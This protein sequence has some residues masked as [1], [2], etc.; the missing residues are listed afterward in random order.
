MV[1]TGR[2]DEPCANIMLEVEDTIP[3]MHDHYFINA[4]RMSV[5]GFEKRNSIEMPK[6]QRFLFST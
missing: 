1:E 3:Q 6:A 5:V 2:C 4:L